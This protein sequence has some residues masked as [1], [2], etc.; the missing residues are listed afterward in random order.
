[1]ALK[2]RVEALIEPLVKD[3]GYEL[4]G[5]EVNQ[6]TSNGLLR[7]YIDEPERGIGLEDCEQV[8]RE[9]SAL[10]D[11]HDPIKGH[12]RL[13]V[14]SPGLDRPLFKPAQFE[15]FAGQEAKVTLLAPI[16]GQRRFKARIVRVEG[17]TIEFEHV[18][19]TLRV[20]H[21]NIAKARLVPVI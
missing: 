6:H 3:L 4:V 1:M 2:D 10:M 21:D 5:L 9:V 15:R 13:E 16:D 17:D 12:Y 7:I 19:G 18:G 8:S 20:P 14:S 11:V